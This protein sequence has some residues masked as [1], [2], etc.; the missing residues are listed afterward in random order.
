LIV[1]RGNIP[2]IQER[3]TPSARFAFD[4]FLRSR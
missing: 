1:K 2:A 3:F 4:A